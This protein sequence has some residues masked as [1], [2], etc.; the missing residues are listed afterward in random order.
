MSEPEISVVQ[1]PTRKRIDIAVMF[2]LCGALFSLLIFLFMLKQERE[3]SIQQFNLSMTQ[4]V[5]DY[6][7]K[8][9]QEFYVLDRLQVAIGIESGNN[10]ASVQEAVSSV[11]ATNSSVRG[12]FLSYSNRL[13]YSSF[14]GQLADHSALSHVLAQVQN[15]PEKDVQGLIHDD[16]FFVL[17]SK[18]LL[19]G[20]VIS[21]LVPAEELLLSLGSQL[22][23]V[24]GQ[25]KKNDQPLFA[26][27]E[28][29]SA[30]GAVAMH[31]LHLPLIA[32]WTLSLVASEARLESAMSWTPAL[33]LLTGL[34]FSFLIASYLKRVTKLLD[35]L[36]EQ[37][38]DVLEQPIDTTLHDPLTGLFNRLHFDE[39]LDVE[40]R[41]AVREFAPLTLMLIRVDHFTPYGQHYGVQASEALLQ[42]ISNILNS[43]VGRPGDMIARLDDHLFGLIL[44]STNEQVVQLA[45][46]CGKVIREQ[47]IPHE[48]SPTGNTITFSI[49]VATLQ[50]SRML[51]PDALLDMADKQLN[52]AVEAGGDQFSAYA[53]SISE[54]SAT[55][56]V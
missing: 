22:E 4:F 49:G 48:A 16:A 34:L 52:I 27:G 41:R 56:S 29:G 24:S 43:A 10:S 14:D 50:P 19:Q 44:P 37:K 55:Y 33:F 47:S 13:Q 40:C 51:T 32:D 30:S 9:A 54:P 26:F 17:A 1:G 20:G 25:L 18:P 6:E 36:D 12:V 5:A 28:S 11:E 46:R 38:T 42:K 2:A 15:S 7:Q 21:I 31:D 23:G 39:T 53:E 3:A 45:E 35:R 8:L